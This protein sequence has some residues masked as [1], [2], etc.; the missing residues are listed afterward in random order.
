[1]GDVIAVIALLIS[2]FLALLKGLEWRASPDLH[3]DTDWIAANGEPTTLQIVV[4]NRG[5]ARG[6][7]RAVLL[8]PTSQHDPETAVQQLA[9]L[10]ELPRMIG[11]RELALFTVRVVA[12]DRQFSFTRGVLEGHFS[13]VI[14]IDDAH[15]TRSFPITPRPPDSD[16]RRIRY[17]RVAKR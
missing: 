15:Q 14:L 2:A 17:G 8:S 10:S 1:V 7:V 4:S 5:R 3:V 11:P 13:H 12:S 9:M 16:T 6:G